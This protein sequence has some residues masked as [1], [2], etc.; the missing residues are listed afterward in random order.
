MAHAQSLIRELR[1]LKLSSMATRENKIKKKTKK[2]KK[3]IKI[4]PAPTQESK[5]TNKKKL[6]TVN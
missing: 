2:K 1:S 3:Q 4:L 6:I 5:K